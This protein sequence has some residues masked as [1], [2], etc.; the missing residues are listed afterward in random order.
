M[1]QECLKTLTDLVELSVEGNPACATL[2]SDA[3]VSEHLR[4]LLPRLEV[5]NG[6]CFYTNSQQSYT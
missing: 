2:E 3:S 1:F 6:V 5:V 4:Q